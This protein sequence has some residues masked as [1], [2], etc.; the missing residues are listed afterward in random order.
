M[1]TPPDVS[2]MPRRLFLRRMLGTGGGL[3]VTAVVAACGANKSAATGTASTAAPASTVTPA[4]TVAPAATAAAAVTT[5]KA[6]AATSAPGPAATTVQATTPHAKTAAPAGGA[7]STANEMAISFSF[8][9]DAA[10]GG[11]FHNPY[12]AVWIEDA[13]GAAV[14]SISLNY[15]LGR[16]DKWLPDLTRWFR[17]AKPT[18]AVETISS[19]TKVPGAYKLAWDGMNDKKEPV[20]LGDYFVCIEAARE[21]GPYQIVREQVSVGAAPFAKPL[22]A[23]GELQDVSVELRARS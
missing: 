11:R 19:A 12:V 9:A 18:A 16:G 4:T 22:A 5:V 2:S 3:V 10:A 17:T 23:K 8:V 21:K 20:A 15:Q 7:F 1:T 6:P 13:A 14:R